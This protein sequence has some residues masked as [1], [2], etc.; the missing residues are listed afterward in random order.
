MNK[1]ESKSKKCIFIGFT[2]GFKGFKLWDPEKRSAF[3]SRDVVF[4]EDLMLREKSET[5]DKA[6]CGASDSST[7]TQE[8]EIKFSESPKRPEGSEE[9]SSDSD[10]DDQEATQEQPR[11]LKW[12]VRVTMLPIRHGWEDDYVSIALVT[13]T[14]ELDSYRE[15]IEADDHSKWIT[16]M[17]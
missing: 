5:E 2:K 12:S 15:A 14:G 7:V 13:E 11:P 4:D 1:L 8:K 10:R 17:K 9:N 16:T 6:Q 3:T